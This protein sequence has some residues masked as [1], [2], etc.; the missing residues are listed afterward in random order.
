[1]LPRDAAP[2]TL[3]SIENEG[4]VLFVSGMQGLIATT[5][6]AEDLN[7][8][9]GENNPKPVCILVELATPTD[10]YMPKVT[11]LN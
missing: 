8:P 9:P 7:L 3:S 10:T 4:V 11:I 5:Y 6:M 1:L 2:I